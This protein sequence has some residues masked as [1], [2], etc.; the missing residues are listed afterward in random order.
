MI[1]TGTTAEVRGKLADLVRPSTAPTLTDDQL[2]QALL[3][4]RVKDSTGRWTDDP[5]YVPSYEL[6]WAAALVTDLRVIATMG[7]DQITDFSS[8]GSS[9]SRQAA[10]WPDL[11]RKFRQMAEHDHGMVSGLEVIEVS[12][13]RRPS[14]TGTDRV[15]PHL[16]GVVTNA[17]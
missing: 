11:A 12:R 9:F 3:E 4:S 2:D 16:S 8:E 13:Q 6:Y 7:Q 10:S 17:D 14:V 5:A 15:F 1:I